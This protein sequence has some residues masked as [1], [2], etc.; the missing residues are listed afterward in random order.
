[1]KIQGKK[2]SE[3]DSG[4]WESGLES[5]V[6]IRP[7]TNTGLLFDKSEWL[8]TKEAAIYLRKFSPVGYPS[9]KISLKMVSLGFRRIRFW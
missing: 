7:G 9:T 3:R 4:E 5:V 2:N 8:T 6:K 1:M